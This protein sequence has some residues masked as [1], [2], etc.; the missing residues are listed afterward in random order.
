MIENT[1]ALA[2]GR[3]DQGRAHLRPAQAPVEHPP[4]DAE[5]QGVNLEGIYDL[6]AIRII[7]DGSELDCYQALGIM[8]MHYKP[9]FHR[10]R[11]FIASPKENG[12]QTLHTTV[13]GACR[14]PRRVPDPHGSKMD[15]EASKG[16]A[17][18]WRYKDIGK[19]HDHL[20]KDE[21]WL[22]FIRELSEEDFNSDEFRRAHARDAA[23]RPGAGALADGRG[24]Q[25]AGG[26]HADRLRLL[27]PHRPGPRHPQRQGQRDGDP[28][29]LPVAQRRRGG[30][31]Q[32]R[33]RRSPRRRR[34]GWSWPSRPRACSRSGAISRRCRAPSASP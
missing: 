4:E 16:I 25:P 29:R 12:Y 1:R 21:A 34:N 8:H 15:H 26:Q 17:A 10:F 9:I 20:I 13:I 28:A 14:Q 31:D 7:I 33:R 27:H 2:A 3:G 6:L 19:G 24:G 5:K 30:G 32:V 18:H 22:E 11:D 23:G